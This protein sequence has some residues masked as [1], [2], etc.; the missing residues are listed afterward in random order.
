M[1]RVTIKAEAL[2]DAPAQDVYA[3]IADYRHGHPQIIPPENL[4]DLQ[5]EAGGY[6][7]GT[8]IRFKSRILGVE[9]AF[10]QRVSEP[11][12]GRVLL[13]EDIDSAQAESSRFTVLPQAGG[14]KSQVEIVMSMLTSPGLKGLLERLV[15]SKML[16]GILKKELVLL[17]I[18]ARK[19][20]RELVQSQ[21]N[22]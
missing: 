7:A 13:E 5:V 18:A 9:Q 1:S 3:T 15:L 12:P 22:T 20:G 2:I 8:I 14:Q 4:Y 17:E 16:P 19:S 11:E 10:Y 6:G 21:Q